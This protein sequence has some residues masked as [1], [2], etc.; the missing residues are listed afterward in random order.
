[1][2]VAVITQVYPGVKIHIPAPERKGGRKREREKGA[3]RREKGKKEEGREEAS[4][5]INLGAIAFLSIPR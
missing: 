1:M 5:L 4:F 3:G 2:V